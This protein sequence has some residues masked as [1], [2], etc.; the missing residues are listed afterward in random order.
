MASSP[1]QIPEDKPSTSQP[2]SPLPAPSTE[3]SVEP[4]LEEAP[5]TPETEPTWSAP[6]PRGCERPLSTHS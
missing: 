4:D 1:R 5:G 6:E 3:P 2:A